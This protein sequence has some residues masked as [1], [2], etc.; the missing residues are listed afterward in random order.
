MNLRHP[1]PQLSKAA[2]LLWFIG[3]LA[4]PSCSIRYGDWT[5]SKST[6]T[7]SVNAHSCTTPPDFVYVFYEGDS[8]DLYC[9]QVAWVQA[10]GDEYATDKEVLSFLMYEASKNCADGLIY[11]KRLTE[12]GECGRTLSS[13]EPTY[14]DATVFTGAAVQLLKDSAFYAKY[15]R[16]HPQ[17]FLKRVKD[18]QTDQSDSFG[19]SMVGNA[20]G[21]TM[22]I[23]LI[24]YAVLTTSDEE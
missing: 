20:L 6:V 7:D 14:Y 15:G 8:L 23:V 12:Q 17:D 18:E 13:E 4:F 3:L 10:K 22:A 19:A 21:F 24:I 16:E 11:V 1:L 2:I 9:R 5:T